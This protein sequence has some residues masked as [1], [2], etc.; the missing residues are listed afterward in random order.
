[1]TQV[2]EDGLNESYNSLIFTTRGG[3]LME[4]MAFWLEYLDNGDPIARKRLDQ[5]L[6]DMK[7]TDDEWIYMYDALRLLHA[8]IPMDYIDATKD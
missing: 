7:V 1:M 8:G 2:G 3:Q 6:S 4:E 5:L